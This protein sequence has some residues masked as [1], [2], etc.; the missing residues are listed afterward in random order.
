MDNTHSIQ[1]PPDAAKIIDRLYQAGHE[2]FAVGGCVRDACLGRIPN[3]WDITT[4]AS[5]QEVV[6]LFPHTVPTGIAHGTVTVLIGKESFEVTTY[7][8]DGEYKDSR[9]PSSVSFTSRL[10]EDLKRRD[11]TI[12]AMAYNDRMGLVDLF[13]GQEDLRDRVIRC[14]GDPMER[15]SEDALRML[16]AVRFGAQLDFRVEKE[17]SEAVRILSGN[18][19]KI[20][21]ERIRAELEKILLCDRPW[22]LRSAWELGLTRIFLPEFDRMMAQQQNGPRHDLSVGEHTLRTLSLIPADRILRL[23]MLLHDMGKT[24]TADRGEDGIWRF[25]S[26][27]QAGEPIARRVMKR[28]KF[29]NDTIR[30]VLVLVANHSS[31]PEPDEKSVRHFI[32]RLGK[33][34]FERYLLVRRADILSLREEVRGEKLSAL[35]EMIRISRR[36][37]ERGDC[38]SLDEM[39]LSGRDLLEDGMKPGREVGRILDLLLNEVLEDPEV[40]RKDLLL[41]RSRALRNL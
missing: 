17:T 32:S 7:R 34:S 27:A 3:D 30:A 18:L 8:I 35:E 36:I 13:H 24:E 41:A 2:A 12:N 38:L 6:R 15:F 1:I 10:E 5:P 26:H 19:Q 11:F 21:A 37:L 28:L 22:R 20:S 25:P 16:R 31:V 40:N 33:E 9:H 29:D 4:S 39:A 14:V 23:S